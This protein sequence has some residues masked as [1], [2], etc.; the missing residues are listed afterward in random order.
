[1]NKQKSHAFDKDVYLLG[2]DTDG[3][4]YWL[5][6]PSWDCEWYWG[7]G[8]I[9]TYQNNKYPD[10]TKDID[11]HSHATEFMSEYFTEFN[12]SKPILKETT[13]N[14]QEGWELSE[15]FA[16]F[17]HL[18]KQA[19]FWGVGKMHVANTQIKSWEDKALADKINK[20]M[21]PVV[22]ARIMQILSPEGKE[23]HE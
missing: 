3:I 19:E 6:A 2:T 12:G 1:M 4:Y 22:M 21:I 14:E 10:R 9:E 8:Y 15:L 18:Q 16:Q 5:Q 17:Y 11:S 23:A 7:F 20:E 13:F